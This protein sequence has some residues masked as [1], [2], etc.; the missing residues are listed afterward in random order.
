MKKL[1][2]L[3]DFHDELTTSN[4]EYES[5]KIVNIKE[6]LAQSKE[7]KIMTMEAL[8][9]GR[10]HNSIEDFVFD[11]DLQNKPDLREFDSILLGGIS[12]DQCVLFTR[13]LSYFN[14]KHN[15]VKVL[16]DCSIQG[17][18]TYKVIGEERSFVDIE[19]LREYEVFLEKTYNINYKRLK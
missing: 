15:N 7:K 17:L 13:P 19:E 4:S 16:L 18:F 2:I 8:Y 5:E 11:Y 6:F 14:L 9:Y 12:L 1:F 3:I 10:R